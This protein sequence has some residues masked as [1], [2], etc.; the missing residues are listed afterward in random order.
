MWSIAGYLDRM[1]NSADES[2]RSSA[3]GALPAGAVLVRLYLA[4]VVC[5][6]TALV[7]LAFTAPRLAPSDAVGHEIVVALFA[8]VL[9]LRLRRAQAGSRGAVRAVGLIAAVLL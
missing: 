3:G 5:T 6:L 7:V 4:V 8:I 9:P 2:V 1:V